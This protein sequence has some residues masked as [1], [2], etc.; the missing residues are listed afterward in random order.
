MWKKLLSK[1]TPLQWLK[2]FWESLQAQANHTQAH[3]PKRVSKA[4]I[5]L[6]DEIS[7]EAESERPVLDYCV[8]NAVFE[9][10]AIYANEVSFM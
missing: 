4:F 7:N 9:F 6:A 5:R 8:E 2:D 1:K 3:Y 10:L